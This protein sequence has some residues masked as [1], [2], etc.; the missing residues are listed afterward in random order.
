VAAFKHKSE[1]SRSAITY[2][3][4]DGRMIPRAAE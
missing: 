1:K 4:R 2:E 3:I